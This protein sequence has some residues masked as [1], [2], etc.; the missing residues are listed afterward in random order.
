VF[1]L[2]GT[3]PPGSG[4][5]DAAPWTDPTKYFIR[6]TSAGSTILTALVVDVP[7]TK[8]WG[9]DR[10]STDNLRDS[11]L[12]STAIDSSIGILSIDFNDKNRGNL[13]GLYLQ[14]KG[15]LCGY[16]PD[17]S[18]TTYDKANVRDGHYPL[19]GYVHF[20]TPLNSIGV[21][22]PAA[23]AMV[24]LFNV[25]K[26]QQGLVDDIIAASLTPQCAMRVSRKSEVGD[27]APQNGFQCGCYFDFKTKSKTDCMTCATAEDCPGQHP[28]NY[29]YCELDENN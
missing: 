2:G 11:L 10:L 17:S 12:A 9:I 7:K 4:M 27:F 14:S 22:D 28:C 1:G 16:Q 6:N 24:L 15:Q 13:K 18:P 19:W 29:G 3:A 20:F 5:K 8:F 26:I 25:P 21:P 23:N